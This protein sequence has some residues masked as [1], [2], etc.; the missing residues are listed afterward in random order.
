MHADRDHGKES[1]FALID[2]LVGLAVL[3]LVGSL[4]TGILSLA[5]G[6]QKNAA[7]IQRVGEASLGVYRLLQILA[8]QAVSV[9]DG[10]VGWHSVRGK[11][12]ELVL[13]SMGPP[14]LALGSPARFSLR[15]E[16]SRR[17]Y[18]L[19]MSWEDPISRQVRSEVVL[20]DVAET[21]FSYFNA[22]DGRWSSAAGLRSGRIGAVRLVVR[23][24]RDDSTLDLV[25]PLPAKLPASCAADP[26]SADCKDWLP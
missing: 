14:V 2:V 3:G 26:T 16:K 4:L 20:A 23:F 1:G 25:A 17:G 18:D 15:R 9:R 12:D 19:V 21:S 22:S 10:P 11:S 8:E 7:E 5:V 13:T 6:Q 24:G